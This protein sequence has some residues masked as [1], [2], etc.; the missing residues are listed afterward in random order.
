MNNNKSRIF[1]FLTVIVILLI[2]IFISNIFIYPLILYYQK[3][4]PVTGAIIFIL[5]IASYIYSLY[6]EWKSENNTKKRTLIN[7]F[8]FLFQKISKKIRVATGYFMYLS[9]L[10]ISITLIIVYNNSLFNH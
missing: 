8:L 10:L 4:I 9:L 3:S 1:I 6:K 5:F 2:S 7:M